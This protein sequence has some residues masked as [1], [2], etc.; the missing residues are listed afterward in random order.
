MLCLMRLHLEL[1]IRAKGMMLMRETG[2]RVDPDAEVKARFEELKYLE[3]SIGKT[4]MLAM[5]PVLH[6]SDH[7][8]WQLHMLGKK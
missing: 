4:G 1:S 5:S 3:K 7:D 2:F 8:L 6:M